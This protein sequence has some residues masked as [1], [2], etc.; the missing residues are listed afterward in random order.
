MKVYFRNR[1]PLNPD[2]EIAS[3]QCEGY[4][5]KYYGLIS[6]DSLYNY[7]SIILYH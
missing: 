3:V 6:Y 2:D 1:L 7:L 5:L 4:L